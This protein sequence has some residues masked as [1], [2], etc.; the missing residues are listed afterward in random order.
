MVSFNPCY[1]GSNSKITAE[2]CFDEYKEW[3]QSLL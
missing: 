3:F 1:S 2:A